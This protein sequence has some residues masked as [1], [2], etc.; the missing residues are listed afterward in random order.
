MYFR[1]KSN[2]ILGRFAAGAL[3]WSGKHPVKVTGTIKSDKDGKL[4][5]HI[6]AVDGVF[7][8][9]TC[10]VPESSLRPRDFYE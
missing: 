1:C 8:G 5:C 7:K 10:K 2:Q 4:Y 9:R 6:L 3:A